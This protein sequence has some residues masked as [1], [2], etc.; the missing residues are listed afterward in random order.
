MIVLSYA[1]TVNCQ[2]RYRESSLI[3]ENGERQA[4][5]SEVEKED[6]LISRFRDTGG[7]G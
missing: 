5:E 3:K 1:T 4:T 7:G 2:F 6:V